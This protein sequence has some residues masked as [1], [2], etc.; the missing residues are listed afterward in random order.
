MT[1]AF[2]GTRVA[3][4]RLVPSRQDVADSLAPVQLRL[5][6]GVRHRERFEVTIVHRDTREARLLEKDVQRRAAVQLGDDPVLRAGDD[7]GGADHV[8]PVHLTEADLGI[9]AKRDGHDSLLDRLIAGELERL[10]ATARSSGEPDLRARHSIGARHGVCLVAGSGVEEQEQDRVAG[11]HAGKRI[12]SRVA[13]CGAQV[14]A[15]VSAH[16]DADRNRI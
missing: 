4:T 12:V 3:Q 13:R 10:G 2:S 8:A 15:C 5:G 11:R 14:R 7:R 1:A 6:Q 9:G 16:P